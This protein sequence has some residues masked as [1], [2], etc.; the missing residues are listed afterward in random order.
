MTGF[1]LDIL[2]T[3]APAT[4]AKSVL[5]SAIYRQPGLHVRGHL[6]LF[7][8]PTFTSDAVVGRDGFYLGGEA[9]YDVADGQLKRYNLATGFASPDYTVTLHGLGNL[10]IFSAGYYHKVNRDVEAGAKAVWNSKSTT[11]S[12][13]ALELGAKT[14]LDNAAFVSAW[15]RCV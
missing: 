4:Q 5:A 8:G 12:N 7:K 3:L 10:S 2:G 14:Y 13:I 11:T 9:T 1:K 6:D 15:S